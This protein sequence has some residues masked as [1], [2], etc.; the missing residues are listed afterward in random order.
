[1]REDIASHDIHEHALM[2]Q[3]EERCW[4]VF[5][6]AIFSQAPQLVRGSFSGPWTPDDV[7]AAFDEG[8][9]MFYKADS[10]EAL[11][12]AAGVDAAG[13]TAT[14]AAYNE[15]QANGSDP[16][17][18]EHLPLPIAE[19]PFYAVQTQ[20]WLLTTFAGVAVDDGL[21]V[22]REDGSPIPNLYAAGELLGAGQFMGRSYCGGMLVTPALTFGRL[23]GQKLLQFA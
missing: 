3:P 2:A 20:S 21:R 11:A 1:M 12:Q 6:E 5:D 13:L 14:V 18:R 16:F 23:I 17:G 7:R 9:K 22:I 8:M 10:L 19:P 4:I 15:S